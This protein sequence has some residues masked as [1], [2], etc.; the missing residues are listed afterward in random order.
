MAQVTMI[1]MAA[2]KVPALPSITDYFRAKTRKTSDTAARKFPDAFVPSAFA[3]ESP[4]VI[5]G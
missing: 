1:K 2:A 5:P 4:L 3:F